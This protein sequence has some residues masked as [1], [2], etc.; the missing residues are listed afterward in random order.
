MGKKFI[1]VLIAVFIFIISSIIECQTSKGAVDAVSVCAQAQKDAD[2]DANKLL[3]V[4]TGCLLGPAGIFLGYMVT[5]VVP[6]TR[7]MGKPSDYTEYYTQCY[8]EEA[9]HTQGLDS[10]TGCVTLGASISLA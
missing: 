6:E 8:I 9:K 5:P 7:I 3:W 10:I 4:A 2:N 1:L